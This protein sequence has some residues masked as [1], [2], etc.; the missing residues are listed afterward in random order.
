MRVCVSSTDK[1]NVAGVDAIASFIEVWSSVIKQAKPSADWTF[2][3]TTSGGRVRKGTLHEGFRK[4]EDHQLVGKCIDLGSAYKQLAVRPSHRLW[5]WWLC[6]ILI[7]E[8]SSSSNAMPFRLALRQLYTASI[9]PQWPLRES[10]LS[11]SE[12]H[13]RTTSTTS[14]SLPPRW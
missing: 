9:E 11:F 3:V 4:E 8:K 2:S 6:A 14:R 13:A 7:Q 5:Q 10:Y 1:V 12:P